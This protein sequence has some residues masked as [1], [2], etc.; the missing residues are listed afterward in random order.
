MSAQP[1]ML[2]GTL[3]PFHVVILLAT[4]AVLTFGPP[5]RR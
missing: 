2:L 5:G 4:L 1:F 3:T